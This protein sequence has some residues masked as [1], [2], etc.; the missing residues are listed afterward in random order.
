MGVIVFL[1]YATTDSNKF[2]IFKIAEK[3]TSYP[4]IDEALYWEE[5]M[6]DDIIKYMNDNVGRCDVFIL[7]CSQNALTSEPVEMELAAL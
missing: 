2:R 7:F 1:S 6:D 4:E 5:D 3:L